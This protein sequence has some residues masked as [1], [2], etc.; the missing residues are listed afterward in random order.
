M[1][2]A[3]IVLMGGPTTPGGEA[4]NPIVS[5]LPFIFIIAIM[6]FM[7]IR[8]QQKK[9]KEHA[10]MVASLG[11]GAKVITSGGIHGTVQGT[12]DTTLY[13][14]IAENVK[15]EIERSSVTTVLTSKVEDSEVK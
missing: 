2:L 11:K 13:V 10:K 9:Q 3:M 14:K 8:P 15:I 6:Y 4:P 1:N 5:F 7:M 12:T